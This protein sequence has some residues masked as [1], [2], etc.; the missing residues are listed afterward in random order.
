MADGV[1]V[2]SVHEAVGIA[3]SYVGEIPTLVV[4][5]EVSGF[6]G[7][8]RRSGHCYFSL[9]DSESSMD[10]I[11]WRG[12]YESSGVVL[13]DGLQVQ[14]TGSF[15]VYKNSGRLSFVA[16][17]LEVAGEG[18]LR[19]KVAELARKLEREGLMDVSRKRPV[20]K[21]CSRIVVVTSLS[22]S[23]I[24]DVKRTLARR[25]PLVRI[26]VAGCMVQGPGAERTI[27]RALGIA[28]AA[29]PDAILL[30]RGGGS[31]ED[32][33]TFNDEAL[34]RA[35][36]ACSVPVV[37]GIG[38]EPDT[39]ICDMVSDMRCSTPTA[40]AEAVAP[41]IDMLERTINER[42]GRLRKVARDSMGALSD[43]NQMMGERMAR[44]FSVSF[45][46]HEAYVDSLASRKC[47][48]TPLWMVQNR[49]DQLNQTE[50]RLH[51]ALP[52]GLAAK[53]AEVDSSARR[54]RGVSGWLLEPFRS[55]VARSAGTLDALSPLEVLSRGYSIS[56]GPDG[57]VL[58]SIDSVE[59]GDSLSVVLADGE[60]RATV[61][62]KTSK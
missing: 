25:N 30:V 8:N 23:V 36:A 14:M 2:L 54:L 51:A 16:K 19:Q 12:V 53:A 24:D 57:R 47:L 3:S 11:V 59:R 7:P 28:A 15:S 26:Q 46:R 38:H 4:N 49:Q 35:V 50:D 62:G 20:P 5:G 9:K 60:I 27:I 61:N 18:A 21:F 29:K 58:S 39:S 10:A 44:A 6:R 52:R 48:S 33:M 13:K 22:G 1:E 45:A 41:S 31:F 42:A 40:A 34:A 56:K 17:R 32:L 55:I 43:G 37:T